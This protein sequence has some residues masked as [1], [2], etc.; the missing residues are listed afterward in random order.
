VGNGVGR[1]VGEVSQAN[2]AKRFGVRA[3]QD[4]LADVPVVGMAAYRSVLLREGDVGRDG[5][6][7]EREPMSVQERLDGGRE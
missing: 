1:E 7:E 3:L 2:G 4:L 5:P 6:V